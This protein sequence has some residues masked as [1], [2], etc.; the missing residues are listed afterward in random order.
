MTF[1]WT[2]FLKLAREL[3]E[4]ADEADLPFAPEAAKRTAVSRAYYSAFCHARNYAERRLGS[5]RS[6]S[7]QDHRSLRDFFRGQNID[8]FEE[9]AA[10][11]DEARGWRNQCD[12]DD[13]VEELEA[14]VQNAMENA[15]FIIQ[16]CR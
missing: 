3:Q 15:E 1:D 12:Y 9:V 7:G 16:Q 4:R 14:I 5:Q 2:E 11:L 10:R 8:V 13:E 6:G